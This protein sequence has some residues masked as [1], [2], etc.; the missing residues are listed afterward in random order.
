MIRPLKT[1]AKKNQIN[2]E[3][4]NTFPRLRL[5]RKNENRR[6]DILI[7]IIAGSK[8]KAER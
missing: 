2:P 7:I 5:P 1:I 4:P 6:K 3:K 8:I